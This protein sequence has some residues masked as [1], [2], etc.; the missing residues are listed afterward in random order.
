VE[1]GAWLQTSRT[2]KVTQQTSVGP[3]LLEIDQRPVDPLTAELG[4]SLS[5]GKR[6]EAMLELGTNSDA[7][8]VVVFSAVYRF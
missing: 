3:V 4:G 7:D 6:W 8:R 2:P 1:P 5:F